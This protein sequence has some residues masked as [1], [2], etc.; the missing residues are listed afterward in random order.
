M[1]QCVTSFPSAEF[2]GAQAD[3]LELSL[4]VSPALASSHFS[5]YMAQS[6]WLL[7]KSNRIYSIR[8]RERILDS[9]PD[10]TIRDEC[11]G[12]TDQ[13]GYENAPSVGLK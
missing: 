2:V 6:S 1:R 7:Y 8:M 4:Y 9:Q 11:N 3:D 12:D 5:Q 10:I 13:I